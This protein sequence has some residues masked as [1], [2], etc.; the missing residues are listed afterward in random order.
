[1]R[2]R[3][4]SQGVTVLK[5][6]LRWPFFLLFAA[7]VLAA[8]I[9][10][11]RTKHY[12]IAFALGN[13]PEIMA[14]TRVTKGQPFQ[15]HVQGFAATE[16]VQ[17]SWNGNG[18]QFLGILNTD[19]TGAATNCASSTNCV[20]S[21]PVP[22]GT[23]TLTAI[24]S[25]SRLQVSTTVKAVVSLVVTTQNV[26]PGSTVQVIGNGFP[27][28]E[29]LTIYLQAPANGTAST[30]TDGTGSFTRALPLPGTY[31]PQTSYYIYVNN[32]HNI[33]QAK[34]PFSF[35]T[36]SITSST[37]KVTHGTSVTLNGKGFLAYEAVSVY[38]SFQSFGQ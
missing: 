29:K 12:G 9:P 19:A 34:V 32:A 11:V 13:G 21:P 35:E 10:I 27:A 20:V 33:V 7:L 2:W 17:L 5:R 30:T 8:L 1:M 24:G 15:L 6:F 18:G 31:S 16:P 23:Y 28:R 3:V 36:P 37:V 4:V 25:T 22:A 26:G 38:A 14:T